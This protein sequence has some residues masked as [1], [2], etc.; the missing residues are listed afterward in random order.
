MRVLLD[1]HAVVHLVDPEDLRIA[2]VT[3][4]LVVLAHDER[5]NRLGR[6][7]LRAE[8][9]ETAA[10]EI[11]VE[12][13][14]HLDLLPG[15]A[16]AAE[17]DEIIGTRLRALVADDAG[18]RPGGRLHLQPQYAAEARRRRPALGGVLEREGRLRRVLQREPQSLQLGDEEDRLEGRGDWL[19]GGAPIPMD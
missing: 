2:A 17:R 1:W 16:V 11:E 12:V 15:L 19:R 6:A 13:I 8:A 10:G 7:D 5:L 4:K 9:T 18:L 14:E 3:A